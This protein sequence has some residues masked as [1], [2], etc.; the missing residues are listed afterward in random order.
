MARILIVYGTT[1]G[2]TAKVAS[3]AADALVADGFAVD[4]VEARRSAPPVRPEEYDG[5]LVAGSIHVG[6][7]QRAVIQWVRHHAE[8]LNRMPTAFLSVCL[9]ILET[10][11]KAEKDLAAILE[12]FLTRTGWRPELMKHV[13]GALPYTRY[14]WLKKLIM[15]RIAGKAGGATDT[16][17]DYE[18]TDWNDLRTTVQRYGASV[19][20]SPAGAPAR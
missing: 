9:A 11:P 5:V 7:Y 12:R 20:G 15:K 17:R 10:T 2:H 13:A 16:S 6:G 8:A 14:G 19:R 1:D 18:Y 4:V 3:A